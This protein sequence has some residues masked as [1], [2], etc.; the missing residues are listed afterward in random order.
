MIDPPPEDATLSADQARYIDQ[1]CDRFEAAWKAASAFG[2]RPRIEEAM[3]EVPEED[4]PR[5]LRELIHLDIFYRRQFG[6]TP[7]P[8]DYQSRFPSLD[9]AVLAALFAASSTTA[10]VASTPSPSSRAETPAADSTPLSRRFRCPHCQNPI[11]LADDHSN[12]V[13]CPGCGSSFRVREAKE[14]ISATPMRVLQPGRAA[15]GLG[16]L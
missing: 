15:S 8:G 9:A 4:R 6:E 2:A 12:E 11:Q 13:L 16:Q 1:A 3:Q 5:L 7:Q 10:D 14:T